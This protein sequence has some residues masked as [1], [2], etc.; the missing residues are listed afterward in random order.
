MRLI[1]SLPL[2]GIG[3]VAANDTTTAVTNSLPLMGIG[4][5]RAT[6]SRRP[7]LSYSLPLMGIGNL[8]RMAREKRIADHSLP[9][10]GIGNPEPLVAGGAGEV[11]T[12]PHGDRKPQGVAVGDP[13]HVDLTTPHGDRKRGG[14]AP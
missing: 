8:M 5:S 7:R 11:L 9:L 10:M 14:C 13:E 1:V 4:N 6:T 12:T 3:N 2:M